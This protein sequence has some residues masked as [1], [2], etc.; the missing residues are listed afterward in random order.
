MAKKP[1]Q[2]SPTTG[3]ASNQAGG[4]TVY[5]ID[6]VLPGRP[7]SIPLADRDA[8]KLEL[9]AQAGQAEYRAF[10]QALYNRADIVI[11]EDVLAQEDL[12]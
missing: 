8:G 5:S 7:E 10:L 2:G 9:G 11:G 12:F 1:A 6:A 3:S 4:I